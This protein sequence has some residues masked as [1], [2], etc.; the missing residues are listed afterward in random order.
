MTAPVGFG[1]RSIRLKTLRASSNG[2]ALLARAAARG[3]AAA[4]FLA[5]RFMVWSKKSWFAALALTRQ[6]S[7]FSN[8]RH[9][10]HA[11]CGTCRPWRNC[12]RSRRVER[13]EPGDGHHGGAA[14]PSRRA[15]LCHEIGRAHV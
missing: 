6:I 5:F 8:L 12:L 14:E 11:G 13:N 2:H 9:L 10:F 3:G 4:S 1:A 7:Q 15:H